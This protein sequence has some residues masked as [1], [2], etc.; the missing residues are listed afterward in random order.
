MDSKRVKDVMVPLDEYAVVPRDATLVEA[1]RALENAQKSL[2][3]GRQPY[4]AVLVVD[5]NRRVVGK[6]GQL[7]FLKALEPR[8][9]VMGDLESLSRAGVSEEF[10]SSMMEHHRFFQD[11]LVDLCSR[12]ATLLV[13]DVMGPATQ[14]IDENVLLSEA[15][16]RVVMWQ[17]LS[18][19]VT[20]GS[21]VVGLLRLSDLFDEVT[22]QMKAS[23]S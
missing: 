12:A 15:I 8:Y 22:A 6:I 3:A 4:R 21:D 19:L 14:S 23:R 7:A 2:P 11:N 5:E 1:V 17:T 10:V 9:N 13:K 18:V 16:H 20:R